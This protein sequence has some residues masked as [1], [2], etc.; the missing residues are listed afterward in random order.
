MVTGLRDS[1]GGAM[2]SRLATSFTWSTVADYAGNGVDSLA[3]SA[4][5]PPSAP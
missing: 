5:P 1:T 3:R 4:A 2:T